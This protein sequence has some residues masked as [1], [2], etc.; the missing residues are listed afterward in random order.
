[1]SEK[2]NSG[3]CQSADSGRTS[4]PLGHADQVG[5]ELAND[6]VAPA[7]DE[8]DL[9]DDSISDAATERYLY[10]DDTTPD[11]PTTRPSTPTFSPPKEVS[12]VPSTPFS[13]P[14]LHVPPTHSPSAS[15]EPVDII[16]PL[17]SIPAA[18]LPVGGVRYANLT[19]PRTAAQLY[20]SRSAFGMS[21]LSATL[22]D[23]PSSPSSPFTEPVGA[24]AR[25]R[26][27]IRRRRAH[28]TGSRVGQRSHVALPDDDENPFVEKLVLYRGAEDLNSNYGDDES[29][30][31]ELEAN[32]RGETE[33]EGNNDGADASGDD[34]TSKNEIEDQQDEDGEDEEQEDQ[35]QDQEATPFRRFP[36]IMPNFARPGQRFNVRSYARVESLSTPAEELG[37]PSNNAPHLADIH[38]GTEPTC[39]FNKLKRRRGDTDDDEQGHVEAQRRRVH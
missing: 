33:R 12:T 27:G 15:P 3:L 21:Y 35:D 5:Q 32:E 10:G 30:D 37:T 19:P 26:R 20:T 24:L 38:R 25:G 2:D 22:D 14:G 6:M 31:T 9:R 18:L 7:A 1:M 36:S 17:M 23:I 16:Q 11:V 29:S 13:P 34:S 39:A 4:P 28:L 8:E